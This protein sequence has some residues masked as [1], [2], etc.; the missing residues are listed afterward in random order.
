MKFIEE[1][2]RLIKYHESDLIGLIPAVEKV[3]GVV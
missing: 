1:I 2:S 3:H